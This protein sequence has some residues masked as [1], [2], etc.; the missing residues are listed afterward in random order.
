MLYKVNYK[1]INLG[2]MYKY[3]YINGMKL[4][5]KT[6]HTF[7]SFIMH[8]PLYFFLSNINKNVIHLELE[9]TLYTQNLVN[10]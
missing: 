1:T 9:P 3:N 10:M 2:Q 7:W 8:H 6:N 5:S 4:R